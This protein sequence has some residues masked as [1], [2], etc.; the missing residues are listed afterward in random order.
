MK[1]VYHG[2]ACFSISD[3]TYDLLIDPFLKGNPL[4]DVQPDEV[5]P[6]H[7]LVTHGH[8]DHLGDA[9]EIARR[10]KAEIVAP[11]ELAQYCS[12]QGAQIAAMHIGGARSFPF[13][14]LKMT[15]AWHGSAIIQGNEIIYT[16]T[17]CGY[18]IEM[19]GITIYHAGDTGLFG[20]MKLIGQ[21][22][23]IDYALLPIGDNY[24]MGPYD[25]VEA[26]LMLQAKITIPMHYD[27]FPIIKQ[28]PYLY[29]EKLREN[30]LQ[31]I[32]LKPGEA[33]TAPTV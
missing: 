18:I 21:R 7:I 32:V 11:N 22:N 3:G 25:A 1:L 13:G 2:H 4:A 31:G 19:Q 8:S 17:P 14:R 29:I 27:T 15:P 23:Q 26:A 33:I 30:G 10:T 16:G 9:L 28:N 6:T 12:M 5:N 20:D 24:V